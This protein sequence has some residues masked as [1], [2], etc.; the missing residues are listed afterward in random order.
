LDIIASTESGTTFN[1]DLSEETLYEVQYKENDA[2]WVTAHT[3]ESEF[4][5]EDLKMGALY[6]FRLRSVCTENMVS[7]FSEV[8]EFVFHGE[9]TEELIKKPLTQTSDLNIS[10]YPNPAVNEI[11]VDAQTSNDAVYAIITASGNVIKK[12]ELKGAIN[13][14]E[15]SSGLYVMMVQD[16]SGTRSSKFYKN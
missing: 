8:F 7:E 9:V 2:P 13:V 4:N 11:A 14:S 5:L 1:W 3:W 6:Q 16:Y 12:G 15:L 10:L